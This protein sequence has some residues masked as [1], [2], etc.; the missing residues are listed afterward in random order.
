[1]TN[2][3][4]QT[5]DTIDETLAPDK[6]IK[7]TKAPLIRNLY[8][9]GLWTDAINPEFWKKR[10]VIVVTHK[11][12]LKGPCLV[13]P[14]T[15]LNQ[16]TNPWAHKLLVNYIDRSVDTWAVC[17]HLM[18]V[19]PSRLS[20]VKGKVPRLTEAEF[21]PIFEKIFKLFPKPKT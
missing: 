5:V 17:N 3:A 7:I 2:A 21:A 8:W 20:T 4:P 18:T 16:D 11:S 9:C 10:P 1:L 6:H 19:S 14:L 15:T 13:V 12:T